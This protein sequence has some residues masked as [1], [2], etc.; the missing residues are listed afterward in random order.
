[1]MHYKKNSWV[2]LYIQCLLPCGE[3]M[4]LPV[5]VHFLFFKN[6]DGKYW[7][8]IEDQLFFHPHFLFSTTGG[9]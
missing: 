1:M 8:K 9:F 4:L 5:F 3:F 2:C 6:K 7:D